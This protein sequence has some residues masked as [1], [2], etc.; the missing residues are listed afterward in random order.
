MMMSVD[1]DA[2]HS[3]RKYNTLCMMEEDNAAYLVAGAEDALGE[4]QA[5]LGDAIVRL[6]EA[7]RELE[8]LKEEEE[9]ESDG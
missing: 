1:E 7:R 4:A 6:S 8:R 5:D 9:E 2:L 3:A